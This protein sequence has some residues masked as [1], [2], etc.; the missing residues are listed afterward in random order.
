VFGGDNGA[1]MRETLVAAGGGVFGGDGASAGGEGDGSGGSGGGGGGGSGGSGGSGGG[2]TSG[3]GGGSGGSGGSGGGGGGGVGGGGIAGAADEEGTRRPGASLAS[4]LQRTVDSVYVCTLRTSST[5]SS[6]PSVVPN[7]RNL[8]V[9]HSFFPLAD[10]F[11]RTPQT[12]G[13]GYTSCIQFIHSMK[14]SVFKRGGGGGTLKL[15]RKT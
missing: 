15:K 11:A 1:V 10:W 4:P 8:D 2:G 12:P 5:T 6:S 9:Y 13:W 14:M 7:S 3:G